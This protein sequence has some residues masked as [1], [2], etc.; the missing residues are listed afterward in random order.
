MKTDLDALLARR[1][2]PS[3]ANGFL[4]MRPLPEHLLTSPKARK[5]ASAKRPT[6]RPP[7]SQR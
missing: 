5:E 3:H 2:I 4:P 6:P 7:I 1:P